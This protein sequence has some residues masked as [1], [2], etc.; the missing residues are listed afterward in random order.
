METEDYHNL[1]LGLTTKTRGWKV[2]GQEGDLGVISHVP[3]S[4]K[5]VRA[6]TFT[7]PSELPC[8]ELESQKDFRIFRAQL[9]RSKLI[10][11]KISLY[12]WKV[13]EALM[14]K[15]NSHCPFEI[16]NTSY[17]QKK[18]R[19]SNNQFDSRPLKVKNQ[20]NF[21][22]CRQLATYRWKT[23]D[24]SYNFSS[25]L[26]I[27]RGLHKKL[28]AL[29]IRRFLVVAISGLPLGSPKDKKPF[30]CGPREEA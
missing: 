12:H 5:S 11:L 30:G 21:V 29:K 8:W 1:S 4:A 27:I 13:A 22:A 18:G 7:L 28:Y 16:C 26:I 19:E 23:F 14:S 24:K 9:Q 17:G 2:A 15:M 20:P 25:N 6:W 3:G 10:A